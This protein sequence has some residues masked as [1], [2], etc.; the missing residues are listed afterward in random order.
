MDVIVSDTGPLISL[1][2]LADGYGWMQQLYRQIIVPEAVAQELYQGM[3]STWDTYRK[4]YN[5]GNFVSVVE[6]SIV[7]PFPGYELL[8]I[9]EREAIQLAWKQHLSLLIEEEQGRQVAQTL[10]LKFSGLAGQILKAYREQVISSTVAQANFAELLQA[11][12]IGKR[13]YV[14]LLDALNQPPI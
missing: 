9:G 2:K 8:D 6:I 13:L 14:G 10:G 5:L 12:R 4:H 3:F 1:E 11:G 7:E